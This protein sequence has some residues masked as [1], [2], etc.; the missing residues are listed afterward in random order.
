[1]AARIGRIGHRP[2]AGPP[3]PPR[4]RRCGRWLGLSLLLSLATAHAQD[5]AV[6]IT[7]DVVHPMTLD[8]VA[9]RALPTGMHWTYRYVRDQSEHAGPFATVSGVR[10]ITSLEQA[11]LAQRDRSDWRKAVVIATGRN[12]SRAVFSW[13]VLATN[14]PGTPMLAY[15]RDSTPLVPPEG[16]LAIHVPSDNRNAPRDVPQVQRIEVRILRD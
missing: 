1:M 12:G 3:R 13:A 6:T 14:A 16:P 10:L 9:L 4:R 7:G 11:E 15:E 8:L 2:T 5:A